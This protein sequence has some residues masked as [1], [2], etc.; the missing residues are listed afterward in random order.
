VQP[1]QAS[2]FADV[3]N[4]QDAQDA[5]RRFGVRVRQE[6]LRRGWRQEDLAIR[7]AGE[8]VSLH[9]TAFTKI[10]AG[11]KRVRLTEAVAIAAALGV[12]LT[13]LLT[14]GDPSETAREL[15]QVRA[16]F[17]EASAESDDALARAAALW[18]RAQELTAVLASEQDSR[19]PGSKDTDG[20][21]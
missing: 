3:E 13:Y 18:N 4:A 6:R 12:P 10:E 9:F 15:E 11:Q 20:A 17:R 19:P 5:E 1:G 21:R 2:T 7:V 14:T 16:E 8:G